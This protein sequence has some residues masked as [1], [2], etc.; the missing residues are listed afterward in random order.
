MRPSSGAGNTE[1]GNALAKLVEAAFD[2]GVLLLHGAAQVRE[3][4]LEVVL[5]RG[6]ALDWLCSWL[7]PARAEN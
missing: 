5:Q 1:F 3:T 2:V 7:R 6:A 4:V